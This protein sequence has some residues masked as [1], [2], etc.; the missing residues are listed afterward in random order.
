[1]TSLTI[2]P[3][4]LQGINDQVVI[5][6]GASS[7]IGLA[8]VQLLLRHGAKVFASDLNDMP[9]PEAT[10]V[11]FMKVDVTSWDQQLAM[12]KAAVRAYG[13]VHHVFGNAGITMSNTL[14][15]DT[16]DEHG[17]PVPPSLKTIDVNVIGILY[18]V[19]LGT[20]YIRQSGEGGSIVLT[21]SESSFS[22]FQATDY[23]VSKH[24]VL[25]LLR[26]L[27]TNL[28]PSTSTS[29]STPRIRINAIAPGWTATGILPSL[30]LDTLGPG[31]Y[32]T[33]DVVARSVV[34]LMADKQRHGQMVYSNKGSYYEIEDG[35]RG[36]IQHGREILG[37]H[38]GDAIE[39]LRRIRERMEEAK[40]REEGGRGGE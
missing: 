8:T 36:F 5:V 25:G 22:R 6:T 9:L 27:T 32:Q 37:E 3:T 29:T 2:S 31:A 39:G 35:E 11:S 19:K 23:T 15:E 4:D 34:L 17:D 38:Y 24:G 21:A 28:Q 14:L 12:F 18:T 13:A 10:Q 16:V 26:A 20:H 7:G 40:V 1:M 30:V 33:P